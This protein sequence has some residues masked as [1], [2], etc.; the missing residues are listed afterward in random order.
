MPLANPEKEWQVNIWSH[1]QITTVSGVFSDYMRSI[2]RVPLL[3][4]SEELHC[5][6]LVRLW[7]DA[8]APDERMVRR[9]R[10]A[11]ERMV[12]ANL[13]LVVSVVIRHQQAHRLGQLEP[14]D[15][16]QAGNLGLIRAVERFDPARGY[17]FSTFA[18]WWIRQAVSRLMQEQAGTVRIPHALQLLSRRY[19]ELR[20]QSGQSQ[21]LADLAAA[22]HI[23]P[24][25]L[26]QAM[27]VC[28]FSSVLSL[29]QGLSDA[30]SDGLVLL[31]TIA[32]QHPSR[33]DDDYGWLHAQLGRLT[34]VEQEVLQR[35][36]GEVAMS[37]SKIAQLMGKSR[38][39]VQ[40]IEK[41][42]IQRLRQA[43]LPI[44]NP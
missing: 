25:R 23:E 29:D 5:G 18:F 28:C 26:A 42:A 2:K 13:R 30:D 43:V 24:G 7:L 8:P 22:L 39:Q 41:R 38:H 35:R 40:A 27:Q 1:L 3:T 31:D 19:Q 20:L 15:L 33:L 4:E 11:L 10:R 6:R 36:Y 37:V 16:I 34:P 14:I 21:A 9:G 32:G 44:L 12:T 17:R